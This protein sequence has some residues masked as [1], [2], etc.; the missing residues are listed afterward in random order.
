MLD[1]LFSYGL[2]LLA[3]V[4]PI[5]LAATNIVFFPL[6]ALWLFGARCTFSK[7]PPVWGL[8]EKLFLIFLGISLLSAALGINPAHSLREIKNK[9]FYIL[10]SLVLVALV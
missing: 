6:A 5:S 1:K 7:W 10:I 4:F 9:D 8:P 3:F 2:D